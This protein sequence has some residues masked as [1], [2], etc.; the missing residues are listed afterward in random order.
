MYAA[1]QEASPATSPQS[2]SSTPSS[3]L[4]T[5][6]LPTHAQQEASPPVTTQVY[7]PGDWRRFKQA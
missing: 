7:P 1:Q 5:P 4:S 3:D 6:S 2:T